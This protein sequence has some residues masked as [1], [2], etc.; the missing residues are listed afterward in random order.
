MEL[1]CNFTSVNLFKLCT[2][3]LL[4]FLPSFLAALIIIAG[5]TFW[6]RTRTV[7][8]ADFR[9]SLELYIQSGCANAVRQE[10]EEA[11]ENGI[12]PFS[13]NE[14]RAKK[15]LV[16]IVLRNQIRRF[17]VLPSPIDLDLYLLAPIM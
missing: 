5:K 9:N 10:I 4:F 7:T 12:G 8:S 2:F 13:W 11:F 15:Q 14:T 1:V 16:E 3:L 6:L 17:T